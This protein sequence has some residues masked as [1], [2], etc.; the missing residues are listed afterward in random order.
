MRTYERVLVDIDTQFDFL[1]PGGSLYVP[2]SACIHPALERLFA[3]AARTGIPVISTADEHSA[4]DPEFERF[5]RHCEA[6]TLGQRK[7]PFTVLGR[8]KVIR[9]SDVLP[10]GAAVL[11]REFQQLIF[12]KADIDVFANPHLGRLIESLDVR[13]YLVFGV[14][15]DYCV[16]S[17]I[18]GLL[19]RGGRVTVVADAIRAIEASAG[20]RVLASLAPRGVRF[21]R[22]A[23]VA[24]GAGPSEAQTLDAQ[25][26]PVDPGDDDL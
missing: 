12:H 2:G 22:S 17:A 25:T 24:P 6:G 16:A 21:M 3:Y 18:E 15:T 5:G 26:P 1:D 14:A 11:L 10:A 23:E 8:S 9:P 13:E 7:L 19:A 4:R 20:E